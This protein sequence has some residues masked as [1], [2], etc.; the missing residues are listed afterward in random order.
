MRLLFVIGFFLM[1]P[2]HSKAITW[3]EFWEPFDK[4]QPRQVYTICKKEI[5][6]EQYNSERGNTKRWIEVKQIPCP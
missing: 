6:Y 1:V 2:S 5:Y 4:S 3:K